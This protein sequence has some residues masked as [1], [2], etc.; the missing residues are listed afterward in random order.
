MGSNR[1]RREG[2]AL[3]ANLGGREGA[4]GSRHGVLKLLGTSSTCPVASGDRGPVPPPPGRSG[5][6]WALPLTRRRRGVKAGGAKAHGLPRRPPPKKHTIPIAMTT[7]PRPPG[8]LSNQECDHPSPQALSLSPDRGGGDSDTHPTH[9]PGV[10]LQGPR[11][12][13]KLLG[14]EGLGLAGS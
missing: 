12:C 3:G 10:W 9:Q 6:H 8:P 7:Q 13:S 5:T 11:E 1:P 14:P 4:S 2:G